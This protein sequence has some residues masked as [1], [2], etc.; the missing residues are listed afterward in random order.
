MTSSS[1]EARLA[2]EQGDQRIE[3]RRCSVPSHQYSLER[4]RR[5]R[6]KCLRSHLD[7]AQ[8]PGD[9]GRSLFAFLTLAVTIIGRRLIQ[10]IAGKTQPRPSSDRLAPICASAPNDVARRGCPG[11]GRLRA[12]AALR[13][14]ISAS[15]LRWGDG[16]GFSIKAPP[17]QPLKQ[18]CPGSALCG[19]EVS[20][21]AQ[22]LSA[23]ELKFPRKEIRN[24][25][26]Y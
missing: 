11:D 14:M 20:N 5:P 4:R 3:R 22:T 7:R 10:V 19:P 18:Q 16:R 2:K 8:I 9:R 13:I 6:H 17:S 21:V 25:R 15:E 12:S 24:M 26:N 1:R 23:S